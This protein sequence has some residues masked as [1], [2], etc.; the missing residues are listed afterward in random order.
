[1]LPSTDDS[2]GMVLVE[3]LACGTPVVGTNHSAIPELVTDDTGAL[4][5]PHDPESLAAACR[6]ALELARDPGVADRCRSFAAAYDWETG[7]APRL[8]KLYAAE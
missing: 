1:M 5:K 3:S 2:F 4:C 7:L 8:E 6:R